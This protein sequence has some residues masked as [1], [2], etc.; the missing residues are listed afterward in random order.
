MARYMKRK[1]AL[2]ALPETLSRR[3]QEY[4][5]TLFE[6]VIEAENDNDDDNDGQFAGK[7]KKKRK[8]SRPWWF[9]CLPRFFYLFKL[10]PPV[11]INVAP[12]MDDPVRDEDNDDAVQPYDEDVMRA[13]CSQEGTLEAEGG[14]V[15]APSSSRWTYLEYLVHMRKIFTVRCDMC[16]ADETMVSAPFLLL[17]QPPRAP[18]D[19]N[20]AVGCRATKGLATYQIEEAPR[21]FRSH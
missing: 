11:G 8:D 3:M 6:D 7:K 21:Q 19:T 13:R 12:L 5:E 9:V 2:E 18:A 17:L 4:K 16:L 1:D 10:A 15:P 20:D 14:S